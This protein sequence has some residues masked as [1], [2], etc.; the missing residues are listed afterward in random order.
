M[1]IYSGKKFELEIQKFKLPNGKVREA[2]YI[3]HKGSSVILPVLD[4]GEILMI[5]QYRPIIDKWLYELPAGTVEEGEDPLETAKRELVE[6]TGY[7]AGK[8][9]HLIDF[10][11]SPGV[12][13]ELMHLYLAT[14]LKFVGAK[15]E[16]YEIIEVKKLSRDEIIQLIKSGE[17]IDGKTLASLLYY[18]FILKNQNL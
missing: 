1:K 16:D 7:Q 9:I 3:N 14:D 2:E 15:P 5:K 4:S 8:I 11:P 6:E 12:S 13:N 17:I 10:Y 18:F